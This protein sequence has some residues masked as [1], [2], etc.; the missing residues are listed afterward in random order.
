MRFAEKLLGLVFSCGIAVAGDVRSAVATD[1]L[2]LATQPGRGADHVMA[3]TRADELQL[4]LD[5]QLIL[6]FQGVAALAAD[7][8]ANK[9]ELQRMHA[10]DPGRAGKYRERVDD[11]LGIEP[12]CHRATQDRLHMLVAVVARPGLAIDLGPGLLR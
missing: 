5:D 6:D 11:L 4:D 3:A 7:F 1:H 2:D 12:A 8:A 9:T 10:L